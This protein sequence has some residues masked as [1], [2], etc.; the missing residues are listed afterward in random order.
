MVRFENN[1]W[2]YY[3]GINLLNKLFK[4]YNYN[5]P[6]LLFVKDAQH[7]KENCEKENCI[8]NLKLPNQLAL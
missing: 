6:V 2:E 7:A 5:Y 1:E 4:K 3:A 8:E